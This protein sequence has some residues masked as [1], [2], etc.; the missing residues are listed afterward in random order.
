MAVLNS[1]LVLSLIDKVTAPARAIAGAV[2]TLQG[3]LDRNAR[4]MDAMRGRMVEAAAAGY[5]LYRAIKAPVMAAV[6]FES[7]MADV[8]KVVDFPTPQAFKQMSADIIEMSHRIPIAATGLADIVAAAG[9]AGMGGDELLAFADVAAKVAVAFDMTA[10]D[11]GTALAKIKT[12]LQMSVSDTSALA[13]AI[14]HLSNTSA[15]EAPSII[16][17]MKRVAA[18]GEQYGFTAT[19]TAAIGS[20]MIAAGAESEVA[21]TSFRNV[22]RA[23]A[24]GGQATDR[25][26]EAF[27]RLGLDTVKV[28]KQ[29][30]RDAVGT[31]R[32]VIVR[33]NELPAHLKSNTLSEIFGDEA[34]ALAPLV[35][36]IGLYDN[37]LASVADRASYLGSSQKEFEVRSETTANNMQLF[38][39]KVTAAGIAIGSA[40]LPSL[41]SVVDAL[42]PVVLA[43]SRFADAN[44]RLTTTIVALSAGLVALRVAAIAAQFSLLWMRGAWLTAA[45]AG[46]KGLG[47]GVSVLAMAF[48]PFTAAARS[49]RSAMIGFSAAASIAGTGTALKT[50]GASLLALL[51]PIKLVRLAMVGLKVAMIGTGI[52]AALVAVGTAGAF[53]YQNWSGIQSMFAGIAD[54]I[55]SSMPGAGAAIDAIVTAVTSLFGWF[56]K[57]TGPVDATGEAWRAL[58]VSIGQT[59]GEAIATVTNFVSRIFEIL[60]TVDLGAA[61]LAIMNSLLEG[62]KAGAAAVL[63]YV[64]GIGA[65]IRDSVSS[66]ASG[67]WASVKGAVGLGSSSPAVDGARAAGGP[68][69]GGRT[70]L[71][72]EEGPELITPSRSGYVHDAEDT[73]EMVGA[74]RRVGRSAAQSE[75]SP[76]INLGGISVYPSPGMDEAALAEKVARSID[77]AIRDA[78]SGGHWN[79]GYRVA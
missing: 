43:I 15:S 30:N 68:I 42:G 78:F 52:G 71:V 6:E 7:A 28:A 63:N 37:A 64:A 3:R 77:K 18:T 74:G 58:G 8:R 65:S 55:R 5:G 56:E 44:P 36:Q 79:G 60:T 50:M 31:L 14:N 69:V 1:Q 54:G 66:A 33:I 62:L 27:N 29:F 17:F 48:A 26:R 53:I 2:Q 22:G 20:A 11:V 21:A 41:N 39:N 49:A 61:G 16:E 73:A 46:L 13:D 35:T 23:L 59:I 76:T 9:Q 4:Q 12:Q 70:Y 38:Q 40:L 32:D 67:A 10:G 57:L 51:N 19:Q 75:S 72:G 45:I 25:Q 47:G 34:R 24:K